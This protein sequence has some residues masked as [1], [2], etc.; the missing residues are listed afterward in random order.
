MIDLVGKRFLFLAIS[1]IVIIPGVVAVLLGG[2][3]PGIDFTGG[4]RLTVLPIND[5]AANTEL[6]INALATVGYG[7]SHVQAG[8]VSST[9]LT[10]TVTMDIPRIAAMPDAQREQERSKI[11]HA[12]I[13]AKLVPGSLV[14]E[15]ISLAP[16]PVAA[17]STVTTTGTVTGTT[18]TVTSTGTVGTTGTITATGTTTGTTGTTGATATPTTAP[19]QQTLSVW[20]IADSSVLAYNTVGPTIGSELIGRAFIAIAL[21]SIAILIYLTIVFRRV[22]N[23]FRYGVCAIIALIH[24]VLVVLGVFAILGFLLNE[25]IELSVHHSNAHRDRFLGAR[26]DCGVRPDA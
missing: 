15:T 14:T 12:L 4:T 7:D 18:G 17:E 21:A 6:F 26:H 2:L 16:T 3:K 25:E 20:R 11:A 22:P 9:I 19:L 23:A 24:D 1:L 10:K 13:D 8:T 5:A